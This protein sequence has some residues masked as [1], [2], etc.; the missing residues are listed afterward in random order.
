MLPS[1]R[2]MTLLLACVA[3]VAEST[4]DPFSATSVFLSRPPEPRA[5]DAEPGSYGLVG[6]GVADD[7]AA[8]QAA[9]DATY[10][11][12]KPDCSLPGARVIL[13]KGNGASYRLSAQ[14]TLPDWVRLVGYGSTR[15]L[16]QLAAHTPGF[17]EQEN[18]TPLLRVIN[19][20]PPAGGA[21]AKT[22]STGGNTAF[23][24]GVYNVDISIAK[25]N[26]GAVGI[27]NDAAQGGVLRAMMFNLSTDAL[28]GVASPGWAHQEL[29]F[30][31][32]AYGVVVNKTGAWPSVFRDCAWRGQE[33]AALAWAQGDLSAWEG[34]TLLRAWVEHVPIGADLGGA[35]S[36]RLT[37]LDSTAVDVVTL[38]VPPALAAGASS[39]LLRGGGGM[40]VTVLVGASDSAPAVANP[41][42]ST[43]A[44]KLNS[45]VAGAV[46]ADVRAQGGNVP[47]VTVTCDAAAAATLPPPSPADTPAWPP[48]ADWRSVKEHG[49]VGDGHTDNTAALSALLKSPPSHALYIPLGVYAIR[50]TIVVPPQGQSLFLFGLSCWDVVITLADGAPGFTDPDNLK[51]MVVVAPGG[52]DVWLSGLNVRTGTTYGSSQPAPVPSGWCNPNPGAMALLWRASGGGIQDVFFHPNSWPDNHRD[53][54]GPNTELSLVVDGGGGMF[55]DIWSCN[56]YVCACSALCMQHRICQVLAPSAQAAVE[57]LIPPFNPQTNLLVF[58]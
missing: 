57:A 15:P 39:V 17:G 58:V 3:C 35:M 36:A 9:I 14:V 6:D 51:P 25:G 56:S 43:S 5:V 4:R 1:A 33:R 55:A 2:S 16:L 27:V 54:S 7:T 11:S 38:V 45:C 23:G 40:R 49:M 42:G 13:L 26:I 20:S 50:D 37:V 46:T 10:S 32:G 47:V 48:V 24:T 41:A 21:C 29:V 22:N 31:G 44:Y 8:L 52:A 12:G 19:W 53:C 30:L 28:A 18:P 34:V